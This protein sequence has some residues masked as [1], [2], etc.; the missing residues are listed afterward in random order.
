MHAG[1]N[2]SGVIR[3]KSGPPAV[4]AVRPLFSAPSSR[5]TRKTSRAMVP[6]LVVFL[7]FVQLCYGA[8]RERSVIRSPVPGRGAEAQQEKIGN[9][10]KALGQRVR[11][12]AFAPE[13]QLLQVKGIERG[14]K[15]VGIQVPV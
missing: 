12:G 4:L 7:L 14:S 5:A 9:S 2:S 11:G 6:L 1:R 13:D 3:V 15:S 8:E 10:G